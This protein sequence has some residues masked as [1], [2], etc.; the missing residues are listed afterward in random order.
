[1]DGIVTYTPEPM[2][3]TTTTTAVPNSSRNKSSV[4]IPKVSNTSATA[5]SFQERKAKMIAEARE[6]YIKKHDLK[7]C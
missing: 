5:L 3:T 4:S 7:D 2:P 1:M 6:K